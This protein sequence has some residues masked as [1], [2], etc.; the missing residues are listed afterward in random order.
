MPAIR[1]EARR[2][3]LQ[4]RLWPVHWPAMSRGRSGGKYRLYHDITLPW[5]SCTPT[6]AGHPARRSRGGAERSV[7]LPTKGRGTLWSSAS[8]GTAQADP[9]PGELAIN[10]GYK[11]YWPPLDGTSWTQTNRPRPSIRVFRPICASAAAAAATSRW[12]M[13]LTR[14]IDGLIRSPCRMVRAKCWA[15]RPSIPTSP[16]NNGPRQRDATKAARRGGGG[17]RHPATARPAVRPS[18]WCD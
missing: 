8:C 9:R 13:A 5:P 11:R 14:A 7:S 18:S 10:D 15:R 17:D 3:A 1:G 4:R 12:V 2:L 6:S 16:K